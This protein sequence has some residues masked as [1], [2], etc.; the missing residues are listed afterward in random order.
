MEVARLIEPERV[1]K[2]RRAVF[3]EMIERGLFQEDDRIQL[4]DGCWS[5]CARRATHTRARS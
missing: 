1:V 5:R 4:L 2:L 3:E